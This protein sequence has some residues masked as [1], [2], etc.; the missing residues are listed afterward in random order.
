MR[1]DFLYELVLEGKEYKDKDDNGIPFKERNFYDRVQDAVEAVIIKDIGKFDKA[2]DKFEPGRY[3]DSARVSTNYDSK[4]VFEVFR[5]PFVSWQQGLTPAPGMYLHFG[6]KTVRDFEKL[7]GY[8]FKDQRDYNP[9]SSYLEV[10][11]YFNRP[12]S[13]YEL[14]Y[15]FGMLN[16]KEKLQQFEGNKQVRQD[17]WKYEVQF[18]KSP[19]AEFSVGDYREVTNFHFSDLPE[20]F[21]FLISN[22]EFDRMDREIEQ[23]KNAENWISSASLRN[24]L[25]GIVAEFV[26]A[27]K[28]GENGIT[29]APGI[30]LK[31]FIP[32][33][34][35]EQDSG[36][37][38]SGLSY[39]GAQDNCVLVAEYFRNSIV[40]N[41][42][43]RDF[44]R[45]IPHPAFISLLSRINT[46]DRPV[47]REQ[48]AG[49][50]QSE[51][52]KQPR[53]LLPGPAT[54][55]KL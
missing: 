38:F 1:K 2:Y 7:T 4:M 10:A 11:R 17:A 30:H 25:H 33:K 19:I 51:H 5:I 41:P 48:T 28:W 21:E 13:G 42:A 35:L 45:L 23:Q 27:K 22:T 44:S 16:W 29:S 31:S 3:Y 18:V 37:D 53:F 20:S 46:I 6:N 8:N 52:R 34:Q 12:K 43:E 15:E 39:Y 54:G 47:S 14:V 24:R 9:G 40:I 50:T 36:I 55:R 26:T 49:Q 32:I